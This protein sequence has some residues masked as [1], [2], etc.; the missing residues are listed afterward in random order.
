MIN[1]FIGISNLCVFLLL[2]NIDDSQSYQW[3]VI[4]KDFW[5]VTNLLCVIIMFYLFLIAPS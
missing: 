4:F 1:L 5:L 3:F 2:Y